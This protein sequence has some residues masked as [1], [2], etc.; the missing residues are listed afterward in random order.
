MQD[1]NVECLCPV[2]ETGKAAFI[3]SS[4]R[5]LGHAHA[6]GGF[7]DASDSVVPSLWMLVPE[8]RQAHFL[9]FPV[10]ATSQW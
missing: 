9:L 6:S 4:I 10:L 5:T 3:R 8:S 1:K 7:H 2:L